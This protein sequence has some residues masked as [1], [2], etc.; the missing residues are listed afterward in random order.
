M[1][2]PDFCAVFLHGKFRR[3]GTFDPL[4]VHNPNGY[5][6]EDDLERLESSQ[7]AGVCTV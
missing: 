1:Q 4:T 5:F 3:L 6:D 7:E 2:S